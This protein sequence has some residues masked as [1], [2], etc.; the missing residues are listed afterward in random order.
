MEIDYLNVQILK[1]FGNCTLTNL[2]DI[3]KGLLTLNCSHSYPHFF[4]FGIEMAT[5]IFR[6][7]IDSFLKIYNEEFCWFRVL[8]G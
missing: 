4:A 1:A 8:L 2:K 6:K 3:V 7:K 5:L